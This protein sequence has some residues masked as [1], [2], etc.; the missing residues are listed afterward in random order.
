[1]SQKLRLVAVI[2]SSTLVIYMALGLTHAINMG[3]TT[4]VALYACGLMA[5]LVTAAINSAGLYFVRKEYQRLNG[6]S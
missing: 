3:D 4:L 5:W 1:M 2:V 6:K